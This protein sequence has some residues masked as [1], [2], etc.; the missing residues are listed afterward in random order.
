MNLYTDLYN[1]DLLCSKSYKSDKLA[2]DVG[3]SL[4]TEEAVIERNARRGDGWVYE[5]AVR[6]SNANIARK[7]KWDAVRPTKGSPKQSMFAPSPFE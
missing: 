6:Q 2:L 5:D 1:T 4:Q 7:A 3:K